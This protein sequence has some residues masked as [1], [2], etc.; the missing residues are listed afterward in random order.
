MARTVTEVSTQGLMPAASVVNAGARLPL[1]VMARSATLA[2][3][4]ERGLSRLYLQLDP[5]ERA[6]GS[7]PSR[8]GPARAA[9]SLQ[10]GVRAK[11]ARA[12]VD[13]VVSSSLARGRSTTGNLLLQSSTTNGEPRC[14]LMRLLNLPQLHLMPASPHLQPLSLLRLPVVP[15]LT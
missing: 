11:E 4:S 5:R 13:P 1:Q 3:G 2:T 8:E 9:G 7:E 15:D 6:E 12:P 10:L 14:A